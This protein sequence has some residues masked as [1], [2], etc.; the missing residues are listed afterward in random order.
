MTEFHEVTNMIELVQD[1]IEEAKYEANTA[2]SP[3]VI[4]K[5]KEAIEALE[6]GLERLREAEAMLPKYDV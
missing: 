1:A 6:P 3:E 5:L 4:A 2:E